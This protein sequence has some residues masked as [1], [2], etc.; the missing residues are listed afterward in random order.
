MTQNKNKYIFNY[1]KQIEIKKSSNLIIKTVTNIKSFRDFY[2]VALKVYSDNK[3]WVPPFWSETIGFFKAKELF[4]K[5]SESILFVAYKN[6]KPVGR[7]AAF[8]DNLF[9]DS[10]GKKIGFFGFFECIN[11]YEI[12][13]S[14]LNEAEKWLKSKNI[15]VMQG[16]INGRADIGSGFVTEGFN[17]LPYLIGHYSQPYYVNFAEKY[18]LKKSIDLLSYHIDLTKPIP[19]KLEESAKRCEKNGITI[20]NFNRF[21]FK[22]ELKWWLKM[23]MEEFADHWGY[24]PVPLKEVKTRFGIK[25]L[26]WIV[27]PKLFLV[28]ELDGK[29]IGFRWTLPDYNQLFKN[30]NGKLGIIGALSVLFNRRKINRGRFIVMGIKKDHRGKGIGSCMNYYNLLEMKKRNYTTAE[31]GWIV[32][33]NI[34]SIKAGEKIG[35]QL[36]KSYRVYEKKI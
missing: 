8:I 6:N 25:Q 36:Y 24:T 20:R 17:H 22:K 28:A 21:K 32:E 5:H 12:A 7:V 35:G 31:Y 29:P 30:M 15:K 34:A 4:W 16:P 3:Y 33:D 18:N 2:N 9:L 1:T 27:D 14:L 19:K 11:D 26:R 13:S 10:K 23:F